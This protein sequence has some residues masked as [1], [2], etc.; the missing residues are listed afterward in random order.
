M[1][2]IPYARNMYRTHAGFAHKPIAPQPHVELRSA[3]VNA[4]FPDGWR[5]NWNPSTHTNPHPMSQEIMADWATYADP[6]YDAHQNM[7][8]G[9]VSAQ[10]ASD[11]GCNTLPDS[12]HIWR[13]IG[14]SPGRAAR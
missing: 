13:T 14:P 5:G 7:G 8:R 2:L 4:E 10:S 9:A 6:T 11:I 1:E 12:A 3:G